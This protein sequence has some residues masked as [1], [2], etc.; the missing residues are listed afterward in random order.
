[1]ESFQM[2]N[3]VVNKQISNP[4]LFNPIFFN[5]IIVV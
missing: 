5:K 4:S 2:T 1:M 3:I